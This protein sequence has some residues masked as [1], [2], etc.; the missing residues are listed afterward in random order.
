M[1]RGLVTC[2]KANSSLMGSRINPDPGS[3]AST[4][5]SPGPHRLPC[6][7]LSH[8]HSVDMTQLA[9]SEMG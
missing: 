1:E 8:S 2:P 9:W 3:P 4:A 7:D 6:S 5:L